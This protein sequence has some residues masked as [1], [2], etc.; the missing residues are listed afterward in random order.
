MKRFIVHGHESFHPG[1]TY[2]IDD[3]LAKDFIEADYATEFQ[4]PIELPVQEKKTGK[5]LKD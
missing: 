4:E 1:T 5:K 3:D 2:T